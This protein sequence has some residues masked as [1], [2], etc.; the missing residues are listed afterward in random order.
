MERT[1]ENLPPVSN[2]ICLEKELIVTYVKLCN[3]TSFMDAIFSPVT[4]GYYP[5][6]SL[7]AA[8]ISLRLELDLF[9]FA[10]LCVRATLAKHMKVSPET[11]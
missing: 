4:V 5:S 1:H 6:A 7:A 2:D 3:T 8:D 11:F 9:H 10:R